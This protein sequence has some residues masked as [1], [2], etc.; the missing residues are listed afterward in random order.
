MAVVVVM[1]EEEDEEETTMAAAAAAAALLQLMQLLQQACADQQHD[2]AV[3]TGAGDTAPSAE[4]AC[5]ARTTQPQGV[6]SICRSSA[7][8]ASLLL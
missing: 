8:E 4:G 5:S 1:V 2:A 3:R 6:R 7:A